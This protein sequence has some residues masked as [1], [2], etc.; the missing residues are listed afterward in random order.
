MH[1]LQLT[2]K[3]RFI[4]NCDRVDVS[5]SIDSHHYTVKTS[6]KSIVVETIKLL[7]HCTEQDMFNYTNMIHT[8]INERRQMG[9]LSGVAYMESYIDNLRTSWRR[10]SLKHRESIE[11]R[12]AIEPCEAIEPNEAMM[13]ST[14]PENP[15]TAP[16][17]LLLA[18]AKFR[19]LELTPVQCIVQMDMHRWTKRPTTVYQSIRIM[20]YSIVRQWHLTTD[21]LT[22]LIKLTTPQQ[23]K[24]FSPMGFVPYPTDGLSTMMMLDWTRYKTLPQ[25]PATVEYMGNH[26]T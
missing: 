6:P 5:G 25:H 12:D 16:S 15:P 2:G 17:V 1:P 26:P 11:P 14:T 20:L 23:E 8:K 21:A 19:Y 24:A 7:D 4:A 13:C 22:V 18:V 10:K 3:D 9:I